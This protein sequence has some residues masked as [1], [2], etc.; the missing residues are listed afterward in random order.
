[1]AKET[2]QLCPKC[3]STNWQFPDPLKASES[4][5]NTPSMVNNLYECKDCGY[6]GIFFEV[7]KDKVEEVQADFKK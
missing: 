5:I 7:D 1:M 2:A 3:G 4:M 6:I